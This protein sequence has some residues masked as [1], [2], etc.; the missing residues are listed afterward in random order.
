MPKTKT[1]LK[2]DGK[3]Q[4]GIRAEMRIGE[5]HKH[6][7]RQK[8]KRERQRERQKDRQIRRDENKQTR[9]K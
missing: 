4:I 1:G 7:E 3:A 5:S 6:Q 2:R 8:R 9:D